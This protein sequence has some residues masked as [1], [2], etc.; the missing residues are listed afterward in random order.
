MQIVL[1]TQQLAAKMRITKRTSR[2]KAFHH[3]Y[4]IQRH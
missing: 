1:F 2:R 3:E 4:V